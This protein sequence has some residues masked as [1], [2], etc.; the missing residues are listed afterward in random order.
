MYAFARGPCRLE[1]DIKGHEWVPT[2]PNARYINGRHE[3][4][5][6]QS[7]QGGLAH[8]PQNAAVIADSVMPIIEAGLV[9]PVD[10]CAEILPGIGIE[11]AGGHTAG[12]V[13]VKVSSGREALVFSGGCVSP[14]VTSS[15]AGLEELLL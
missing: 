14:A 4:A 5:H 1:H 10:T 13:H 12:Q 6:W 8:L 15:S 9:E 7:P 11:V 2:F 3:L